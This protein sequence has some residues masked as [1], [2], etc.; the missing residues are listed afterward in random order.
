MWW[1][2]LAYAL[3]PGKERW[4][5]KTSQPLPGPVLATTLNAL[6]DLPTPPSVKRNDPRYRFF[7]MPQ[8]EYQ[9]HTYA[10]GRVYR[11]AGWLRY[12][13]EAGDGD[14][15]VQIYETETAVERCLV[16]E[17]PRPEPKFV[18]SAPFRAVLQ[19]PR[20]FIELLYHGRPNGHFLEVPVFVEVEGILFLDNYHLQ[21]DG[22]AVRHGAHGC[23]ST[24]WELHSVTRFEVIP[25]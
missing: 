23:H 8:W 25:P 9:G 19:Q 20:E 3:V 21:Q 16:V 22:T 17:I 7:R 18:R 15:H 24:A 6:I 4:Y 12:A 13:M 10:E 1:L 2:L 14:Y 11:I 5:V